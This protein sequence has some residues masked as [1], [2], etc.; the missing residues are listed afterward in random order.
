MILLASI[1]NLSAQKLKPYEFQSG[2]YIRVGAGYYA[3]V[4]VGAGY[5][6]P[7]RLSVGGEVTT[8]SMF[9]GVGAMADVRYRFLDN[10]FSPFADVKLGYGLLGKNY[11]CEN[12]YGFM[13][14]TMGGLS[15]RCLDI[16]LGIGVD[17]FYKVSPIANISYT[18]ILKRKANN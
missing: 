1:L 7:F 8:W 15:W 6:F 3:D 11:E 13:F 10:Q 9:C 16:G 2:P 17:D 12:L 14:S 4:N 5:T 18:F